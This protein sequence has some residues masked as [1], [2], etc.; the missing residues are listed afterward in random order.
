VDVPFNNR[1]PLENQNYP[2]LWIISRFNHGFFSN[3]F[4]G[5]PLHDHFDSSYIRRS[6]LEA[7]ELNEEALLMGIIEA[8][9]FR[10]AD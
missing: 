6:D 8:C 3:F 7:A 9:F 5:R 4:S 2:Q 10:L 1:L